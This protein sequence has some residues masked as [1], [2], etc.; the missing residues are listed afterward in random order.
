[1]LYKIL[2]AGEDAVYLLGDF[3]RVSDAV[4]V[5]VDAIGQFDTKQFYYGFFRFTVSS[6]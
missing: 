3:E 5:A 1:M 6:G 2:P 4:A